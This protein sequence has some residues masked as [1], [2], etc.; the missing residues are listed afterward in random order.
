PSSVP[1]MTV[2]APS[3]FQ[4]RITDESTGRLFGD[5]PG[6]ST[7]EPRMPAGLGGHRAARPRVIFSAMKV[8]VIGTGYVGL[9]TGVCLAFLGHDVTCV[10]IDAGKVEMLRAG[11]SP[12]YEPFL[13]DLLAL[14]GSHLT[15]T[16][17]YAE[18]VPG[19]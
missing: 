16:T 2:G 14:A 8:C 6:C 19:A 9:T 7:R 1:L 13:E 11:K 3:R 10:D 5:P 18:G 15:Y 4:G 12:I 17:D